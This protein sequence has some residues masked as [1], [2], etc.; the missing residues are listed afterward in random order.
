MA[1]KKSFNIENLK[2]CSCLSCGSQILPV[3]LKDNSVYTCS[4]CGQKMTVDKYR[5][6]VVLTVIERQDLRRRIPPEIMDAAPEQKAE[7]LKLLRD[8]EVLKTSL[9]LAKEKIAEL[10]REIREWQQTA[11]GLA[12]MIEEM[13]AK[14]TAADDTNQGEH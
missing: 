13:K 5:S 1:I 9:F 3:V 7:I 12:R 8:N 2:Q 4:Q 10:R 6:H 11:D 14:E